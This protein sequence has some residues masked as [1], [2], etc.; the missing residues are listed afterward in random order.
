MFFV[1]RTIIKRVYTRV[2]HTDR[3]VSALVPSGIGFASPPHFA[4]GNWVSDISKR[5]VVVA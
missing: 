1:I 5:L 2:K 3:G 4:G